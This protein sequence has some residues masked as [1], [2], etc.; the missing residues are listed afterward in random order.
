MRKFLGAACLGGWLFF[1]TGSW[2]ANVQAVQGDLSIN[3]GDGFV[4]ING[5][6]DA[7]V[8]DSLMVGPNGS[9]TVSYPDGCQVNVQ[10]GAVATIAPIS[11]CAS[12]SM[13][14]DFNN[15]FGTNLMPFAVGATLGV[16]VGVGFYEGLKKT[17]NNNSPSSP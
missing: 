4:P 7:N 5:R 17:N 11:P 6:I 3:Q 2:A 13:A 14:Q 12:G 10:P 1:P 8:G 16:A 15:P 9:A